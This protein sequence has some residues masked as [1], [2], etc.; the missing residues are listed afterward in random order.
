M[1]Y[2]GTNPGKYGQIVVIKGEELYLPAATEDYRTYVETMH[3]LYNEKLISE[4]YFVMQDDSVRALEKEGVAGVVH[5]NLSSVADYN[6]W[7]ALPIFEIGGSKVEDVAFQVKNIVTPGNIWSS[8]S[9]KYPEVLAYLLDYVYSDE[10]SMYMKYGPQKG[11]DPLG[12]LDGWYFKDGVITND[13]IQSG[14]GTYT[15]LSTFAS[16]YIFSSLYTANELSYDKYARKIA[17]ITDEIPTYDFVDA[18]TG[19]TFVT[20]EKVKYTKDNADGYGRLAMI[21]SRGDNLTT[22]YLPGV[23]MS[24]E[25]ITRSEDLRVVLDE[26]IVT[27]TPRFITGQRPLDEIDDFQAQL[28]KLGVDEYLEIMRNAYSTYL[29]SVFE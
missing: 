28:K 10:G 22:V 12:K 21:E 23:Y 6:D 17:G 16:H 18:V 11:N 9:T 14:K 4:D 8:A 5:D 2:Y 27:E 25:D 13:E 26:Y 7:V 1:G 15:E 24:E 3:T 20:V 19:N 29:N